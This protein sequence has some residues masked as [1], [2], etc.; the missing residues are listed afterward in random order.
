MT[1]RKLFLWLL[2]GSTLAVAALWTLSCWGLAE[3]RAGNHTGYYHAGIWSGTVILQLYSDEVRPTE[4]EADA[5]PFLQNLFLPGMRSHN[6][7]SD[8]TSSSGL[9]RRLYTYR[10]TGEFEVVKE[11]SPFVMP[12]RTFHYRA[13]YRL[14]LPLWVPWLL[15]VGGAFGACRWMEKRAGAVAE[16]KLAEQSEPDRMADDSA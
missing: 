4:A 16:K 10:R 9:S 11:F 3:V 15:F 6:W 2:T 5:V 8:W 7:D 1:Y 12:P 14:D 13:A